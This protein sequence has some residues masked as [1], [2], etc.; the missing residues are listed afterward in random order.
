MRPL[1]LCVLQFP[2]PG[3]VSKTTYPLPWEL[4]KRTT[5]LPASA[6]NRT[7]EPL[8]YEVPIIK[9]DGETPTTTYTRTHATMYVGWVIKDD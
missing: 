2:P 4:P 9:V 6:R 8:G 3:M 7:H 1:E 5:S